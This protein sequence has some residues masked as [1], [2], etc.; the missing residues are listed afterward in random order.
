MK[1]L[2]TGGD[3]YKGSVLIKKLI[4][5]GHEIFN[6]DNQWFGSHNQSHSFLKSY[7]CDIRDIDNISMEG[8]DVV[9]HLANIAN[10]PSV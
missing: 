10:D 2:I 4:E 1:I 3:G 6:Y 9:I 5:D 7:K 8:I